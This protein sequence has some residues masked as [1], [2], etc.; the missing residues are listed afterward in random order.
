MNSSSP[1]VILTLE[2][3]CRVAVVGNFGSVL[4]AVLPEYCSEVLGGYLLD[5]CVLVGMGTTGAGLVVVYTD[6][7]ARLDTGIDS[8]ADTA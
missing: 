7:G 2:D 6:T 8:V 4:V 5:T 3:L 1:L